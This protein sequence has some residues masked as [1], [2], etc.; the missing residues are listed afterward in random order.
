MRFTASILTGVLM[1]SVAGTAAA[2]DNEKKK[3]SNRVRRVGPGSSCTLNGEKVECTTFSFGLD[4][5]LARRAALGV[6]VSSTGSLRDTLGVFIARVTPKGPAE[7]AGIFEGDRIMSINGVDLRLNSADAGDSYASGLASRR[8]TRELQKVTPGNRVSLKVWSGGRVRDVQVTAGK[9]SDLR[10]AGVFG[11]LNG[12]PRTFTFDE[13][14]WGGMQLRGLPRVRTWT[15]PRMKI[16]GPQRFRFE[17]MPKIDF[18]KLPQI[19]WRDLEDDD[20]L[21]LDRMLKEKQIE[22]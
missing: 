17:D 11:M 10:E 1:L 4:S 18:E 16:D 6:Q 19:E 21:L 7:T 20:K 9:A 22:I 2:Q 12:L 13:S 14:P 5:A 3:E 15:G 8:L